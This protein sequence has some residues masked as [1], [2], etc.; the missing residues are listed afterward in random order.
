MMKQNNPALLKKMAEV[1][2]R[3]DAV[4]ISHRST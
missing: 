2:E 3:K 1:A 4:G